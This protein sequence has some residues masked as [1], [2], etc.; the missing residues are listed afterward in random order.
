MAQVVTE[1]RPRADAQERLDSVTRKLLL[2]C[3]AFVPLA[4]ML[5]LRIA[6]G[7][8]S[9]EYPAAMDQA[10]I[11][12]NILAGSGFTTSQLTPLVVDLSDT[13][14]PT[15]DITHP[16]LY[17]LMLALFFG[18][19]GASDKVVIA[20]SMGFLVLSAIMVFIIARRQFSLA[21]AAVATVLFTT[22][23]Q[24]IR[25]AISG[26]NTMAATFF[27]LILWYVLIRPGEHSLLHYLKAG[28]VLGL[29]YLT[30]YS[31]ALLIPV[32]L[33]YIYFTASPRRRISM[34][35][36]LVG[37]VLI[38]MP[39]MTRNA[40]LMHN[41]IFTVDQYDLMSN[42]NSFAGFDIYRSFDGAPSPIVFA[43][44][45]ITDMIRKLVNGL[46]TMYWQW[47]TNAGVYVLPFFILSLFLR[48][49]DKSLLALRRLLVAF[50]FLLTIAVCLGDQMP[51]HFE[52]LVPLITIFAAGFLLYMVDRL[53]IS[54]TRRSA[55][56]AFVVLGAALP[57]AVGLIGNTAPASAGRPPQFADI[58]ASLSKSAVVVTD[59]PWAVA[60][61]GRR[62]A[63]WLPLNP[64]QLSDIEGKVGRIDAAFVSR[65][66]SS[67]VA[68]DQVALVKQLSQ[69]RGAQRFRVVR[70]YKSGDALLARE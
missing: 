32:V 31:F 60:W 18:L 42:T 2:Y 66:A 1:P 7:F 62:K 11:G 23:V 68:V 53:S 21:A 52:K 59:C 38:S 14:N 57:T 58:D 30:E 44:T 55:V 16:P 26:T 6:G 4:L 46:V 5:A 22:Q 65:Y 8:G 33:I 49:E 24:T 36:F 50:I 34:G 41:P 39:W 9:L 45:H 63:V 3:V 28:A 48:I 67:F 29:C 37:A 40:I 64:R 69:L 70:V 51:M 19:F 61:Y 47:P 20:A 17:P 25:Y 54:P 10:Q 56:I 27:M 43:V 12:R 15:P 13:T 35:A